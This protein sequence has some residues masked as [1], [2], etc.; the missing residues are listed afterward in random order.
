MGWMAFRVSGLNALTYP[1]TPMTFRLLGATASLLAA[2]GAA[3]PPVV[4]DAVRLIDTPAPDGS[5]MYALASG[6]AD[7]SSASARVILSWLDTAPANTHVLRYA[8]WQGDRWSEAR[9]V[10]RGP[11]WFANWADHPTVVPAPGGALL[12]HWLVR[13]GDGTSRY[14]YGIRVARGHEDGQWT[15]MF[16]A[17]ATGDDYAGFLAFVPERDGFSAA[18]LAPADGPPSPSTAKEGAHASGHPEPVKTLVWTRVTGDGRTVA[19]DVLDADVCSCCSVSAA[20]TRDGPIVA[21]RD[22]AAGEVR[23]IAIVRRVGQRWSAPRIVHADGWRIPGCPTNGPAIAARGTR[24]VVAWFTA[25]AGVA[26]VRVASSSDAGATFAPPV[27][28]DGGQ[29]IGW[30]DVVMLP[31][32]D[33]AVSWLEATPGTGAQV[34]GRRARA[35]GSLG[36]PIVVA[37]ASGGRATGIPHIATAGERLL[38]AWRDGR[39]RTALVDAAALPAR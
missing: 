30:A 7:T 35:D 11:R 13:S 36:A 22:R 9:E 4:H 27:T 33:A 18:Y 20:V 31:D 32:G 23:D 17:T 10:A 39:V 12:A 19:R 38:I 25:A 21:Y 6:G 28:V 14:G 24:V 5:G 26:T 2:L 16:E 3:Q 8:A 37:A 34:R 1:V 29:P 15:P